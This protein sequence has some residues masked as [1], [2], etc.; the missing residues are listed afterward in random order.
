[1]HRAKGAAH[2]AKGAILTDVTARLHVSHCKKETH[3]RYQIAIARAYF[4]FCLFCFFLIPFQLFFVVVVTNVDAR[5]LIR[6][7][8]PGL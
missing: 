3:L 7:S 6:L 4:V 5:M 1:M 8:L 2:A